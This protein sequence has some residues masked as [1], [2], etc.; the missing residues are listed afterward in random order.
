MRSPHVFGG[1][2]VLALLVTPVLGAVA[3]AQIVNVQAKI[4]DVPEGVSGAVEGS[5]DWRTGNSE[6]LLVGGGGRLAYR[7]DDTLVYALVRGDYGKIFQTDPAT[8]IVAKTFEH[9]RLRQGLTPWLVGEAFVQN[10]ADRFRRLTIRALAGA[11]P[12]FVVAS[13]KH[14][15]LFYGIAYMFEYERLADDGELDAGER[16]HSHRIST[17]LAGFAD[18]NEHVKA[19]ETVYVQ[20]RITEPDD[21]RVLLDVGLTAKIAS[22]LSLKTSFVLA[23]DSS[24][25]ATIAGLDTGL[26]TSFE[27]TF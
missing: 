20:P 3:H 13:A 25:P 5:L 23:Y 4:E 10:E 1:L 17:Y 18:L 7:R 9:V 21:L 12:R 24:P 8:E 27:A 11:G 19:T 6:L 22:R 26:K 2:L 14:Y 15:G 16:Q